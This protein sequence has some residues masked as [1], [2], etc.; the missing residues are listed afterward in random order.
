MVIVTLICGILSYKIGFET[1]ENTKYSY[2][3]NNSIGYKVYLKENNFFD[4]PFLEEDK[5]YITSL[6]DYI[7]ANFAYRVQFNNFV[8]GNIS[9]E[10]IAE[11]KADK[12][13]HD[14]GNYWTKTF[15]LV[16]KNTE[17]IRDRSSYEISLDQKIDYQMFNELLK[18]FIAEYG[19]IA[20]STL[21]VYLDVT[22]DVCVNDKNDSMDIA[23]KVSLSLP[24][25]ELAIE[26]TIDINNNNIEKEIVTKNAE[27]EKISLYMK[28]FFLLNLVLFFYFL[29]QCIL[30]IKYRTKFFTYRKAVRKICSNYEGMIVKVQNASMREGGVLD[31]ET[32]E[33]LVNVYNSIREP[34]N[35][36]YERDR[37]VFFIINNGNCYVYTIKKED[38]DK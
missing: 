33:D 8:S 34:I 37:A 2:K 13:S 7:D 5:T 1:P 4:T 32:F 25:S 11:I 31:V 21:T 6:I 9:Y 30:I 27:R 24:L 17:E 3:E 26:G 12:K 28:L 29:F 36:R 35:L 20:D 38:Y 19:L 16:E 23:S 14:V 15:T 18:S 22:G 10:L